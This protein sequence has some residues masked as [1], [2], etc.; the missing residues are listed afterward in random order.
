MSAARIVTHFVALVSL[1][2]N[3]GAGVGPVYLQE[4][5]VTVVPHA[6]GP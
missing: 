4:P 6:M 5:W 2:P 1:T 3:Y